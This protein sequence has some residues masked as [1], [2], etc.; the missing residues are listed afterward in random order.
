MKIVG[1]EWER[2]GPREHISLVCGCRGDGGRYQYG[3]VVGEGFQYGEWEVLVRWG[4]G[5]R[6]GG[7]GQNSHLV[8]RLES[9]DACCA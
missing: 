2:G 3:K 4:G 5:G 8:Y 9:G 6:G 7:G 1:G